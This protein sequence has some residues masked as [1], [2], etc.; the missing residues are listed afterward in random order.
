MAGIST[1]AI[2]LQVGGLFNMRDVPVL[3]T[4]GVVSLVNVCPG[5]SLVASIPRLHGYLHWGGFRSI[6]III[7][8]MIC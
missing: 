1:L 7:S 5:V 2:S 3:G 6:H 8:Y 4:A